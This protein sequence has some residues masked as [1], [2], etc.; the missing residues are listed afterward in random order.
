VRSLNSLVLG[1]RALAAA[2]CWYFVSGTFHLITPL[3]EH[4]TTHHIITLL[5]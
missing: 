2:A 1:R 5:L 4:R 3:E